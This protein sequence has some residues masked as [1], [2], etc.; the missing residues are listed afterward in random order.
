VSFA[1][2]LVSMA[3]ERPSERST[4]VCRWRT[5]SETLDVIEVLE[6]I[7]ALLLRLDDRMRALNPREEP[8]VEAKG[9]TQ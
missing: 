9:S 2:I 5:S 4:P 8:L 1:A 6:R 3:E 7:E